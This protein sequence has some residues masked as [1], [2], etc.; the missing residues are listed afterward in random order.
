MPGREDG[1]SQPRT[2]VRMKVLAALVTFMFG[3]LT[4]RLWFLQVLAAPEF[5]KA[6][7]DNQVRLVPLEPVRGE[8]LDRNGTVMATNTSTLAVFVDRQELPSDPVERGAVVARLAAALAVP[9]QSI[10]KRLNSVRYLAYQPVPVALDVS[11][12]TAFYLGEH[13]AEFPGVTFQL[14][15]IRSYPKGS[16]ASHVIGYEYQITPSELDSPTY[17]GYNPGDVIGQSGVESSYQAYL[18]GIPGEKAIQVNH[19]GQVIN[20]DYKMTQ[21]TH[22][23]DVI[24]SIDAKVQHLVEQSL[25][26]GLAAA[27]S[28]V[29]TNTSLHFKAPAAAA[30]VMDPKT[31][32]VLALASNPNFDPS[33]Y[34]E[35]PTPQETAYLNDPENNSPLLDRAIAG[36]YPPGSTFK[37]F[38]A[39]A[40]LHDHYAKLNQPFD[41]PAQYLPPVSGSTDPPFHNW[42]PV[43]SGF[44]SLAQALVVS[45]DTVFYPFGWDYWTHYI[46]SQPHDPM[47]QRDLL[48][49]GFGTR[50][51]IDLGGESSGV[52][53]DSA[54]KNQ[55]N[56]RLKKVYGKKYTSYPW[57]PGDYIN[58]SIGQGFMLVTPLQM[59][60]AYSALANG[61]KVMEPHVAWR[62]QRP[63]GTVVKQIVPKVVDRLPLNKEQLSYLRTALTGVPSV[64]TAATAFAGFPLSQIPV[65]GKTGTAQ[66][67]GKQ[68]TSWFCAMA[69]AN[70]PKYVVAVM[71]E[72]G[73]HGATSAAP[74]VRRILEGLFGLKFSGPLNTGSRQ[75]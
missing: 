7:N 73:G 13:R 40:A 34:V 43:D 65:A 45:C 50:T 29:D 74:V 17:R 6:A 53:P 31:G 9:E 67:Q 26:Q 11:K 56:A 24:L 62:V 66:I 33:I 63:D 15:P 39:A 41:C 49:M 69:P 20:P 28:S 59:A 18:R 58:M 54:Y 46:L 70:D 51:G 4:T 35:G 75:D 44:M 37:P 19:L 72:Q 23:D 14:E 57:F 64:G 36:L 68:D 61:G 22:G 42:N 5:A 71:I 30:V 10:W 52:V 25:A 27:R 60:V 3:A 8:I 16:L 1:M 47:M 55:V 48:H 32:Q 2:R 21:P 12:E 38:V